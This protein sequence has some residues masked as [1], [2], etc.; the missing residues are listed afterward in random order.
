M[1]MWVRERERERER[2]SK[3]PHNKQTGPERVREQV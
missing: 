1:T 3:Q 2:G